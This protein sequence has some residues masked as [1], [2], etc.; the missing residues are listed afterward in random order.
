MW[1]GPAAATVN[2]L[3]LPRMRAIA[4]AFYIMM[5]TF[6]GLALGPFTMGKI[7]DFLCAGGLSTDKAL[8]QGMTW[9]L[10]MYGLAAGCML[11][12]MLRVSEDQKTVAGR[13]KQYGEA[14]GI[15]T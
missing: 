12:A 3:V 15:S 13:A 7:S 6:I 10:S 8:T 11:L 9:R 4:S 2:E 14:V 1:V 5:V